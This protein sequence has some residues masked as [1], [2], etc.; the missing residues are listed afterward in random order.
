MRLP[1][2]TK[3]SAR[4][5]RREAERWVRSSSTNNVP[6]PADVRCCPSSSRPR[7]ERCFC[8]WPIVC[9]ENELLGDF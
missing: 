1:A 6:A 3:G 7:A 8:F 5:G 4:E 2:H 9:S